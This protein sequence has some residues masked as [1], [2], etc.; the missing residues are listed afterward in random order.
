VRIDALSRFGL[1]GQIIKRWSL[2]GIK[3]LLPIQS[4]SVNRF[5]LLEG[6]C[7]IISGPGTSGKTFCGEL[8]ILARVAKRQK[9]IFIEPLKAVAEEKYRTFQNRYGPL[10]I[11]VAL[12]TRDHALE[13]AIN[14]FD[15]GIFIYEKFN[16]LSA[17]DISI[18]KGASCFVLDEF[19][20]ISDPRRGIEFE[21]AIMKIRAFNPHAQIVIL[22][23]GGASPEKIASWLDLPLIEENRRPVDLR[24]GVLH[25]GTFHFREFNALHEGDELWLQKIEPDDDEPISNQNLA[26]IKLLADRGE[27]ILIFNSSKKEAMKLAQYVATHL[28]LAE[29]KNALAALSECPQSLQN[30]ALE[31][32]LRHGAAF[33]HA[34]LDEHQRRVVEEGFRTGEIMILSS[35]STLASGVNLPAKNVFIESVKYTGIKTANSR[36]LVSPLSGVDFHQAA[37]RAGRLGCE[38]SFG[39]AIMTATTQFEQEILWDK[40]IYGQS[41]DPIPGLSAEQ[42]PEF[43]LRAISCGAAAKPDEVEAICRRSY[44]ASLGALGAALPAQVNELLLYLDKCGL[45]VIKSWG[46]IEATR[47]GQAAGA[48]GLSIKSALEIREW[49][50][51]KTPSPLECLLLAVKLSEWTCETTGYYLGSIPSDALIMQIQEVLGSDE[52]CQP[53]ELFQSLQDYRDLNLKPSLAAFLFA[54]EWCSGM[55]TQTLEAYFQKG[56]GGLKRDSSALC[57]IL[58]GIERIIRAIHSPAP[59]GAEAIPG[60]EILIERLQYGIDARLLPLAKAAGLDREFIKRLYDG[61]VISLE[62]LYQADMSILRSLLPKTAVTRIEKWRQKY[63]SEISAIYT[64]VSDNFMAPNIKFTGNIVKLRNEVIIDGRSIYL[65]GRLYAYLHKLWW[66]HIGKGGFVHKDALDTGPNQAK[67]ISRLR[68]LLREHEIA[69]EIIS[70][71]HGGYALK[72]GDITAVMDTQ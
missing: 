20:M 70:D 23:G 32:C 52:D 2:D 8:A 49:I 15:I 61:G 69:I 63:T 59:A 43:V 5:G 11:S 44:A 9:G 65:Q 7:L 3:F 19:Q 46:K 57:W 30:E 55:P 33:H 64:P 47:F 14:K 68:R 10:G 34:D 71:G 56:A 51:A 66:E 24:L 4:E 13:N 27:Q 21:L 29:A 17:A 62:H 48:A 16:T 6:K 58:R 41:E 50:A 1:P 53:P 38:K 54:I 26:A 39:R 35:T 45:I 28:G 12:A 36:E 18:I 67:Y 42:L 72:M 22:L 31:Q 60:L 25:R 40:Y 37:G